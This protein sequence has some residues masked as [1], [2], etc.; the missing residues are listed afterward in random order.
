MRASKAESGS[1]AGDTS[2][3]QR[4]PYFILLLCAASF[5]CGCSLLLPGHPASEYT[6]NERLELRVAPSDHFGERACVFPESLNQRDP[7][8]IKAFIAQLAPAAAGLLVDQTSSAIQKE[9]E[10]FEAAY[11]LTRSG[12]F[13]LAPPSYRDGRFQASLALGR[14]ALERSANKKPSLLRAW[15]PS[16]AAREAPERVAAF[17]FEIVPSSCGDAFQVI[18]TGAYLRRSKAKVL[19]P[20][21]DHYWWTR[22]PLG[23]G[24]LYDLLNIVG[25]IDWGDGAID[26]DIELKVDAVWIDSKRQGRRATLGSLQTR[27]SDVEIGSDCRIPAFPERGGSASDRDCNALK[28]GEARSTGWLPAFPRS[29]FDNEPWGLGNYILSVKVSEFDEFAESVSGAATA[30]GEQ[31]TEIVERVV[32]TV[33]E[34]D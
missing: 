34:D 23:Y 14:F 25:L 28:A 18:L 29:T 7:K 13:Y 30:L 24:F 9:A 15:L 10:R 32:E 1:Q 12:E 26:L 17:D 8:A 33:R 5:C 20:Q 19:H 21:W 31:R 2:P 27:L 16:S 6:K 11:S 4:R 3:V 22:I